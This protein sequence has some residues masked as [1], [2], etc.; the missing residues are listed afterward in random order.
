MKEK[1]LSILLVDDEEQIL[2]SLR[3]L[4]E[5]SGYH[6][7]I[8]HNGIEALK[9][10]K[11]D[12]YNV[13]IADI[14]MPQM[15]GL[16]LLERIRNDIDYTLPVILMTGYLKAEHAIHAIR[17]GASDFIRKPIDTKQLIKS[18]NS[19]IAGK[20]ITQ[21]IQ[22]MT[23]QM[24]FVDME[25]Q[26]LPKHFMETDITSALIIIFQQYFELSSSFLNEITLC[27]EE[28]LNNAFIHGT[29]GLQDETRQLDHF[30]YKAYVTQAILQDEIASKKIVLKV[31][32]DKMD[33]FFQLA[34]TDEGK[35]F[36]FN[37]WLEYTQEDMQK[38]LTYH[39]RGIGMIKLLVDEL[40]FQNEGR[41]I[42]I[43]KNFKHVN[44][45]IIEIQ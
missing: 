14:E 44:R 13:V 24:S 16:E 27:L 40:Q 26:F 6:V 9:K 45:E 17:K 36:N 22:N 18:V 31:K 7:N 23:Q 1:P 42:M 41:T 33:K 8:A 34:V 43:R 29:L 5:L 2:K 38:N 35:G 37:P 25:F 30:N 12:R 3:R 39:G 15:D 21:Q 4:L 10:I 11:L 19:L 28:M 32:M 20:N